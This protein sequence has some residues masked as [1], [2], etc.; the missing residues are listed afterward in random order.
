MTRLPAVLVLCS[1]MVLL[2]ACTDQGGALDAGGPPGRSAAG[3]QPADPPFCPD[4]PGGTVLSRSLTSTATGGV[5]HLRIYLPPGFEAAAP[6]SVP[7]LVLLHGATADETQWID[8][9]VASAADCLIGSGKI[10]PL[11]IV[12]VDGSRVETDTDTAPPPMERFLADEVLPYLHGGYPQLAGRVRTSIGG[13]SR[14]GGWALRIA[15]DRPD[16]FS[17]VGGHSPTTPLTPDQ[18]RSLAEHGIRVWLDVGDQDGLRADV[19]DLA[20]SLRSRGYGAQ[21]LT[22]AGGHDRLYWSQHVEDYLRFYSR[23]W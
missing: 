12:T 22:P 8:V 20:A 3:P 2:L 17:S 23:A 21:L 6:G 14:G 16:L 19:E 7:L 4:A 9:G 15:A 5:E 18:Q 10:G 1:T 11:V 13:I